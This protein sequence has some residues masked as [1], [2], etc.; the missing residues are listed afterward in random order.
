MGRVL[1]T[2]AA[3][4][5]AS[6]LRPYLRARFGSVVLSDRVAPDALQDGEEYRPADLADTDALQAAMEGIEGIIHLGAQPVEAPWDTV[7]TPNIIGLHNFFEAARAA[8]VSRVVYASSVHAVGFYPRNRRIDTGEPVR[9]DGFYGLSKVFGEGMAALYA[10]KFGLRSL[11]IRIGNVNLKPIDT[12]RLSIWIHPEDLFQLCEIGLTHPDIHNQVVFGVSDN[13]RGWWDN[14]VAFGLGF[15]PKHQ[16]EEFVAEAQAGDGAP[17]P[18]GDL[19]QGGEFCGIDFEG[20]LE[21]TL[22]H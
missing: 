17:D 6:F 18:V 20:D 2:G 13:A 5:V 15:R 9:P 3:G 19:F 22:W 14:D 12:R 11:S 16:S 21:R 7:V 8:G 1:L 10:D 4:Q